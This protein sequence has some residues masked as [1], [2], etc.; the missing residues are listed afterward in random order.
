MRSDLVETERGWEM[1]FED[2]ERKIVSENVKLLILCSPQNPTGRVW[3]REEL[4]R[5]GEM[6]LEHGVL[7]VSDEIHF[8]ITYP[9]HDHTVFASISGDFAANSVVLTA[10]SKTFNIA[11]M[12]I[13]NVLTPD[14]ALR[15]RVRAAISRDMG[16]Y[17]NAF[18]YAACEAAY[19][20]GEGW[21]DECLKV[22][23]GNCRLFTDYLRERIPVLRCHM[24]DGTYL[25]WMDCRDTGL[26][27]EGLDSFLHGDAKFY[28]ES[29]AV[30]GEGYELFHRVNLACPRRYVEAGLERLEAAAKK[31][32]L[33]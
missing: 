4:R 17:F 16:G 3:T 20:N 27:R 12:T 13:S 31:R 7:I 23:E 22:L 29:G 32:G 19:K 1:D 10:P 24:P 25:A 2:M 26:D 5:T 6:C 30:F 21:L 8:D 9:G 28:S 14:P 18:G 11:G 33:I 15:E